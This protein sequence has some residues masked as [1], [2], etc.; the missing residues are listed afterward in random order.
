MAAGLLIV[1]P[2]AVFFGGDLVDWHPHGI[3]VVILATLCIAGIIWLFDEIRDIR[4]EQKLASVN[5]FMA[6]SPSPQHAW[7]RNE[8]NERETKMK[9]CSKGAS[10]DK[11][12]ELSREEGELIGAEI[13]RQ[14][15]E[16]QVLVGGRGSYAVTVL[17][18]A[19][20]NEVAATVIRNPGLTMDE[21]LDMTCETV[22]E[23]ARYTANPS[24]DAPKEVG[25][26]TEQEFAQLTLRIINTA[27]HGTTAGDAMTATSKALGLLIATLARRPD[28]A[29]FDEILRWDVNHGSE[30]PRYGLHLQRP[31]RGGAGPSSTLCAPIFRDLKS[32]L[33][34][35][36][37]MPVGPF[38]A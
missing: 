22:R 14:A 37:T 25:D 17:A 34:R 15:A 5:P 7:A 36:P 12:G 8:N 30:D 16:L 32:G 21:M 19:L 23:M 1:G 38:K 31:R 11:E 29:G 26:L 24:P 28:V 13:N 18:T 4:A 2:V 35:V 33:T 3:V 6:A 20:A 9:S 10:R 27:T